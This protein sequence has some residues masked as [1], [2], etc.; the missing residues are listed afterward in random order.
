MPPASQNLLEVHLDETALF[1]S[2]VAEARDGLSSRPKL[3]SPKW[4]YD[5]RGCELFDQITRLPEY[6]PTRCEQQILVESADEIATL[7]RADSLVELG[8]GTSTKTRVLLDAL[9]D[10]GTLRRFVP[11]DVSEPTLRDASKV[12]ADAYPGVQ[13]HGVVGDFERHIGL[14]PS[15]GRRLVAF[16][17]STIG[18]LDPNQ[19]QRLLSE[20][21]G[22]LG[23]EDWLLLGTDLV[24]DPDRLVAAYDDKAG[25]TAEFNLNVLSVLNDVLGADFRPERFSHVAVWNPAHERMEM[26]LRSETR[27]MVIVRALDM[28][29]DFDEGEEMRTEISTKFRHESLEAELSAVRLALARWWTDSDGDFAVSLWRRH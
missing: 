17:G 8:A 26:S 5:V 2:L 6:Y 11:F 7:T 13:V 16:L 22:G 15:G 19:R 29:V 12:I 3:L 21:A 1:E 24:K 27:Q 18:N 23:T 20:L 28:V 9:T 4:M 14:L 10:A 25:V